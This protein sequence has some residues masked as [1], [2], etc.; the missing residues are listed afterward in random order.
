VYE[1]SCSEFRLFS[2]FYNH[3]LY[4]N[5]FS[6]LPYR[7]IWAQYV[8]FNI[9][10]HIYIYISSVYQRN[11][12][13]IHNKRERFSVITDPDYVGVW[14]SGGSKTITQPSLTEMVIMCLDNFNFDLFKQKSG[15]NDYSLWVYINIVSCKLKYTS[16]W[17]RMT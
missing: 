14:Q 5:V 15:R 6:K 17:W 9:D 13:I 3:L 16:T 1:S 11:I 7:C 10:L 2:S 12:I 4:I 8:R